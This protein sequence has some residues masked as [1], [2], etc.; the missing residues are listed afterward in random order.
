MLV[1]F[2]LL[3]PNPATTVED[4]GCGTKISTLND[5]KFRIQPTRIVPNRL[6]GALRARGR[7]SILVN[8]TIRPFASRTL[9]SERDL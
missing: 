9:H 2:I 5:R 6:T 7:R 1:P 4:R 8:Q 3:F